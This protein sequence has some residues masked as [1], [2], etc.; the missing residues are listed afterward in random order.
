M[1]LA[2]CGYA[3]ELVVAHEHDCR[4]ATLARAN[5]GRQKLRVRETM[6]ES[7]AAFCTT[8]PQ[9]RFVAVGRGHQLERCSVDR[10]RGAMRRSAFAA[11]K[12]ARAVAPR[13]SQDDPAASTGVSSGAEESWASKY[14]AF[15]ARRGEEVCKM[16][17]HG[18][19]KVRNPRANLS[20]PSDPGGTHSV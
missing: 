8:C 10:T 18:Y 15:L 2:V 4:R 9:P 16:A 11:R 20:K 19:E 14:K 6:G 7:L 5:R 12:P 1:K 17:M 13:M 3:P